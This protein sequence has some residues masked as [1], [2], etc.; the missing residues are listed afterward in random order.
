VGGRGRAAASEPHDLWSASCVSMS[1]RTALTGAQWTTPWSRSTRT[2]SSRSPHA[3]R[4]LLPRPLTPAHARAVYPWAEDANEIFAWSNGSANAFGPV[5][6][7]DGLASVRAFSSCSERDGGRLMT[8]VGR[9]GRTAQR[10]RHSRSCT[11]RAWATYGTAA[12][13]VGAEQTSPIWARAPPERGVGPHVASECNADG[14]P[15]CLAETPSFFAVFACYV[16]IYFCGTR[17]IH[18]SESAAAVSL[19]CRSTM[20]ALLNGSR[21]PPCAARSWLCARVSGV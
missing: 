5:E 15:R 3:V 16:L 19:R 17:C 9:H 10:T 18:H 8:R 20:R 12:D 14:T 11:T 4:R 7:W 6:L 2:T 1:A 21:T 13:H